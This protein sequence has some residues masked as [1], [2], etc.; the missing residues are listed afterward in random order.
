MSSLLALELVV[1]SC[2]DS[3]DV[4]YEFSTDFVSRVESVVFEFSTE[5]VYI[6]HAVSLSEVERS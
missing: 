1:V 5:R 6:L 3:T 4:A 2:C